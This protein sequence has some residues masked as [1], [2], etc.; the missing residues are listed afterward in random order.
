MTGPTPRMI[1][2]LPKP[3][4]GSATRMT[5]PTPKIG[6]ASVDAGVFVLWSDSGQSDYAGGKKP[7]CLISFQWII[8]G[9][10]QALALA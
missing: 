1:S 2:A 7:I 10:W 5:G 3:R 9:L 4:S 6:S 8:S